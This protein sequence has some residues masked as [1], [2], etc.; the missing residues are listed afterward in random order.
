MLQFIRNISITAGI[1]V[2]I[3]VVTLL[4][5]IISTIISLLG[6]V[7]VVV[8]IAV[9]VYAGVKEEFSSDD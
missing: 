7:A 4:I 6:V 5:P 3:G 2:L 9:I 8:A 1:L